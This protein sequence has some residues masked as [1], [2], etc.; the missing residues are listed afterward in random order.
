MA[1]PDLIKDA[2]LN[3]D[4]VCNILSFLSL[5]DFDR[6]FWKI[7]TKYVVFL[8]ASL[9]DEIYKRLS[10]DQYNQCIEKNDCP[11][12]LQGVINDIKENPKR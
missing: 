6:L 2:D 11:L 8:G 3:Q 9:F 12:Y 10:L 1:P 5:E 4:V 7:K